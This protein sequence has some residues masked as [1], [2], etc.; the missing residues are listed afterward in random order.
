M[1]KE[2]NVEMEVV[3]KEKYIYLEVMRIIACFFVLFNHTG[4]WGYS[5]FSMVE[6]NSLRYWIYLFI[7]V[8]CKFSVPLFLAISGALLLIKEE[9][10]KD[11]WKKRILR[12]V[13]ILIIWSFG[14]YVYEVFIGNEN[15]NILDFFSRLYYGYWNFSYWYLYCYI[16]FLI[17]LPFLRK[18]VNNL[19]NM[20]FYYMFGL[21]IVLLGIIPILQ[22]LICKD[23]YLLNNSID[24]YWLTFN[25]VLYPCLGYFLEYR[26]KITKKS[27]VV[28]WIINIITICISCFMCYYNANISNK[29]FNENFNNSFVL[30]NTAT[31]FI[32]IKYYMQK[33]KI[34][35]CCKKEIFSLGRATFGIYLIHIFFMKKSKFFVEVFWV[36]RKCIKFEMLTAIIFSIIIMCVSYIVILL[37]K[38]IP[39]IKKII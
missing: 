17:T 11:I 21:A 30:I 2:I 31:L 35:D 3:K 12:I 5:L 27:I 1:N 19:E 23:K 10:L 18:L 28:M 13:L 24:I 22:F 39:I 25:S 15:F 36:L 34:S 9:T 20:Y 32:T 14:Y 29:I 33:R 7:S 38:K 16:G 6:F 4:T 8:F 26:A 37:M